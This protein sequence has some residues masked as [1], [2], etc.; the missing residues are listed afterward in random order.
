MMNFAATGA[1]FVAS[2]STFRDIPEAQEYKAKIGVI[3][4]ELKFLTIQA[5][6]TLERDQ[7]Q[8][9]VVS[10]IDELD[11]F[12]AERNSAAPVGLKNMM[13]STGGGNF[14]W[15]STQLG[16]VEN[17]FN[18]FRIVFPAAFLTLLMATGNWI[19]SL[20]A[21]ATI[22]GIVAQV[23][24]MCKAI[25]GWELGI[26]ES[27]A[28]VIVIGFSV[29]FTVHLAHMYVGKYTCNKKYAPSRLCALVCCSDSATN[30][31]T[32]C[33]YIL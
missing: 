13:Y 6:V 28:A 1:L 3:G 16:L 32:A 33:R 23:L 10:V 30:A 24:G 20:Y 26:A 29:D 25:F 2:L 17:V 8:N 27:I 9:M 11:V 14:A 19:V 15:A 4:N 22:A 21:I 5:Q 12:E 18:G 31:C 7:P